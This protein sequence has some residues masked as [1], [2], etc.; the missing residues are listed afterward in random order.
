ML[1]H[2]PEAL[3][4]MRNPEST[5]EHHINGLK[6]VLLF[7]GPNYGQGMLIG[8]DLITRAPRSAAQAALFSQPV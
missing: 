5:T 1:T 4:L 3:T 7:D 2:F 6:L 8:L